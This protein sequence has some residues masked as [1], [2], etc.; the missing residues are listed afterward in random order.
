MASSTTHDPNANEAPGE[1]AHSHPPGHA[2]GGSRTELGFAI[3][4]AVCTAVGWGFTHL[5]DDSVFSMALVCFISAYFF[6]GFFTFRE[7]L[8]HLK[9]RTF[10]I[11]LLMLVAALGAALLGEWFE[12]AL[13]LALFSLG[14][15]LEHYAMGKA[16]R[17][18]DSLAELAP[19][20]A[21]VRRG[22]S[23]ERVHVSMLEIG[24]HVVIKPDERIPT[25]GFVLEGQSTVN[26][27]PVTG[28]SVPVDKSPVQDASRAARTSHMLSAEHR[29]YAGSIN[30]AGA[31]TMYVTHE[32]SQSTLARV[33]ELVQS[34]Q[35]M[36][37]PTQRFTTKFERI[38]VP[39]VLLFVAL[40]HLAFLVIDEPFSQSF[41]RAMAV[42]V[43]ASPCALAI[44]T[45]SAVLSAV[46]AGGRSGVLFK[47]GAPLEHL[48][49]VRAMA[50]DK[51]GTLTRGEPRVVDVWLAPGVD[52]AKLWRVALAVEQLS[53][54]PLAQAIVR[55][56]LDRAG[57]DIF[58]DTAHDMQSI[59]GRGVR[60]MY[61][62]AS[63]LIGKA[64]LF[65][66]D[67]AL[68]EA[69]GVAMEE[70][71]RSGYTVMAVK[72]GGED[73]GVIGL[74][75]T[76]RDGVRETLDALK[77]LG[78]ER[79]L[80]LSGDHQNVADA[81]AAQVGLSEAY[82]DL[83]PEDKVAFIKELG[84]REHGVVMVGDGVND[85]PAMAHATVA[86]AMGA[87]GSDTALETAQV[88]LMSDDITR[89]PYAIALGRKTSRIITQNLWLSLGMVA[90][91][92]PATLFGLSLG[93]AVALHE[94]STLL[95]VLNALRLL[96]F[97]L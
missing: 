53:E 33:I 4:A 69:T 55:H 73:L 70:F 10:E 15:A 18:I 12:G 58:K 30:G 83:M 45:P 97:K 59:A 19:E 57:Q 34:A 32:A 21:M 71:T 81:V 46:A 64:A 6:G 66:G 65:E 82:G 37:S 8:E 75:D 5:G 94:G 49:R 72:H 79:M 47:G 38:F 80:M 60:A 22:G 54:H 93:P 96:R 63:V 41:Y 1:H 50:F 16:R 2:H 67:D 92:I 20:Y 61:D 48:G 62:G 35:A 77:V 44:S 90:I 68:I 52:E 51:T 36:Q 23:L 76:P 13:L 84:S 91:L 86:I 88:A 74:M 3:L 56:G 42:L 14:H 7:M 85:A 28:E 9:A 31:M 95:V 11:D 26:Q 89:L 40:L 17:A 25:D 39:S 29:L 87:A 27:A 24:D 43:A 78:V